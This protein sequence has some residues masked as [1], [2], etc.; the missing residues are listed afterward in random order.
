MSDIEIW[1][2]L[3]F[4]LDINSLISQDDLLFYV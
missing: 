2:S 1:L 3:G 4:V